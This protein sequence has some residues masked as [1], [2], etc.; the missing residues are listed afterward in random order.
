MI[1]P[2]KALEKLLEGNKRFAQGES[3]HPNLGKELRESLMSEQKPYAAIIACSD[4]R[5]P[6]EIIF[7]A[8]VGDLFVIRTAGHVPSR[9]SLGSLEYAV[10]HLG[11]KLVVILGHENCGAVKSAIQVHETEKYEDLSEN[12]QV[13]LSHIYPVLDN[14]DLSTP[15]CL[16][17]A[18][19][20]NIKYQV[21]DLLDRDEYLAEKMEKKEIL[22]IGAK[23][24]FNSGIIEVFK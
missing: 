10:R 24:Y 11:V 2:D 17:K 19:D 21:Q 1:S 23:Y 12:L 3:I 18:I 20:E 4:S 7:D 14:L 22:I 6:V 8:G 5:V 9:E 13:L 16:E 15:M